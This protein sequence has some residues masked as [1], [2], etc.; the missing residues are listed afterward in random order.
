[1]VA[2]LAAFGVRGPD[3]I[4]AVL[5]YRLTTFKVAGSLWAVMYEYIDRHKERSLAQGGGVPA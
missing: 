5:V 4:T 1:M 2:A 3:A